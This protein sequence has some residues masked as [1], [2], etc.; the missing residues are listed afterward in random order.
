[1]SNADS[2]NGDQLDDE[3]IVA[4]CGELDDALDAL[5]NTAEDALGGGHYE[6][7][8]NSVFRRVHSIKGNLRMVNLDDLASYTH[9]FENVLSDIRDG[10]VEAPPAF[11]PFMLMVMTEISELARAEIANER[12]DEPFMALISAVE[13]TRIQ[14]TCELANSCLFVLGVLDPEDHS[15]YIAR[16]CA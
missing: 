15:G 14:N 8:V 4:L 3:L 12:I 7:N 9:E 13:K 16:L 1:M 10:M 5:Q 11:F 2:S 6:E